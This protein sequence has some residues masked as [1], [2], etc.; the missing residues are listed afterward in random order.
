VANGKLLR[1]GCFERLWIQP[2]S[3]D[4]GGALG[5]AL[6]AWHLEFGGA[7]SGSSG[8]DGMAGGYLGPAFEDEDIA[9]RLRRA[10]ARFERLHGEALIE[11]TARALAD[12]MAV[13]WFQGRME[14]GPRA[15]GARSTSPMRA[16]PRC[17]GRSI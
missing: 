16:G 9:R 3:G 11:R 15:L 10:G 1:D 7:R 17:S 13:G 14:F 6:A 12:G 4:A 8:R 5:A 2:A